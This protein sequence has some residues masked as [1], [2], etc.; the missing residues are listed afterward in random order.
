MTD[1]DDL[2][3]DEPEL[4][5]DRLWQPT[6]ALVRHVANIKP[7]SYIDVEVKDISDN[8]LLRKKML[9]LQCDYEIYGGAARR[10]PMLTAHAL[11]L[12]E[13]YDS[14][15]WSGSGAKAGRNSVVR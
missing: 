5:K 6:T 2:E 4:P 13:S 3:Q 10:V 1:T 8:E 15:Y 12:P 7:G 9:V 14:E 11:E